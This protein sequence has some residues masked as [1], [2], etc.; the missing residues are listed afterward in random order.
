[1]IGIF[2]LGIDSENPVA[3]RLFVILVRFHPHILDSI[4]KVSSVGTFEICYIDVAILYFNLAVRTGYRADWNND[5]ILCLIAPKINPVF[6]KLI[7]IVLPELVPREHDHFTGTTQ[8]RR[9]FLV[10]RRLY[11]IHF[12]HP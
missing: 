6:S 3:P 9:H 7:Q 10:Y 2:L 5:I 8:I 4:E 1:M 11:L 12:Y